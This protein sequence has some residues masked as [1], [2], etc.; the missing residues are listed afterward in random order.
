MTRVFAPAFAVVLALSAS[1]TAAEE[2]VVFK[3]GDWAIETPTRL[4][5]RHDGGGNIAAYA[6]L[7]DMLGTKEVRIVGV[8]K[9]ACTMFL[10]A[11]NVCVDPHA[12]LGF[13]G[14]DG[15]DESI[16]YL[17]QLVDKIA[18]HYPPELAREFREDWGLY[19]DLTW[20]TGADILAMAPSLRSCDSVEGQP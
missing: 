6:D 2:P 11:Q 17:L 14:P 12:S 16:A 4:T 7:I 15:K 18:S 1:P 20:R 5:I 8:C 3:E 13:H 9:S 19:Q 10:G